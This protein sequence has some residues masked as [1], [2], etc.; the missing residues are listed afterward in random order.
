MGPS[1]S[2]SLSLGAIPLSLPRTLP[3]QNP[4]CLPAR[5]NLVPR[6]SRSLARHGASGLE[7]CNLTHTDTHTHIHTHTHTHTHRHTHTLVQILPLHTSVGGPP[8]DAAVGEPPPARPYTTAV[9]LSC[10]VST[11]CLPP[12]LLQRTVDTHTHTRTRTRTRISVFNPISRLPPATT[13]P[14]SARCG[15]TPP[16]PPTT[17]LHFLTPMPMPTPGHTRYYNYMHD[18][19]TSLEPPP[20]KEQHR[21]RKDQNEPRA[22]TS[23]TDDSS[24]NR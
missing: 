24:N 8:L 1:P 17:P 12:L 13:C 22:V 15:I 2:L 9:F 5:R 20:K 6:H 14:R 3:W 19:Y 10:L 11:V 4:P 21:N 16:T 23:G 18:R 7:T